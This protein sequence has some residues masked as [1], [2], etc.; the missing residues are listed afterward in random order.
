[1]DSFVFNN[2]CE[3]ILWI[4]KVILANRLCETDAFA[5]LIKI[6]LTALMMALKFYI[7]PD[8]GSLSGY[9]SGSV[10][11][12]SFEKFISVANFDAYTVA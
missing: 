9:F 10:I 6:H 2:V 12:V 4:F 1:M 11:S 8:L 7:Y 5:K 3:V